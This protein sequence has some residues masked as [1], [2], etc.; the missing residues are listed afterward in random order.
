M[1]AARTHGWRR[2]MSVTPDDGSLSARRHYCELERQIRRATAAL[3]AHHRL[4][5]EA[6]RSRWVT[7]VEAAD[8]AAVIRSVRATVAA[9]WRAWLSESVPVRA[10]DENAP[11]TLRPAPRRADG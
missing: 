2:R 3:A 11:T 8:E 6:E 5:Q 10:P 9:G 7:P 4:L 1:G